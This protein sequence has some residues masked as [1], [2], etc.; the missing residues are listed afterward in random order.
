MFGENYSTMKTPQLSVIGTAF[1]VATLLATPA[2]SAVEDIQ[3]L[4]AKGRYAEAITMADTDLSADP[5]DPQTRFLKGIALAEMNRSDD[6]IGVFSRLTEDYPELPEPYNNL[7]VLYAQQRDFEKAR[8]ALE[9]AIRTHPSYATAHEN[10]GDVYARLASQA[11]NQALQID[12]ANTAAQSKL[13]L[14]REL[15]T[16]SAPSG[17]ATTVASARA[18]Q[19]TPANASPAPQMPAAAEM[20]ASDAPPPA[21]PAPAVAAESLPQEPA[22]VAAVE[23]TA[24]IAAAQA[25]AEQAVR[26]AV[27]GWAH[28]WSSKDVGAYLGFYTPDFRPANGKSHNTWKAERQQLVGEKPGEIEVA[29]ED[30]EITT[31]G[32]TATAYFRQ[33]YRSSGFN[34]STDKTLRLVATNGEWRI[35]EELIGRQ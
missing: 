22:A 14:I 18:A 4:I 15:M 32:D 26:D 30:V 12:S 7:A 21:G 9:M 35:R 6:A 11:Y 28:A 34:G 16:V 25:D 27:L 3:S 2:Q 5:K 23:S 31:D 1:F 29:L 8:S 20:R 17:A 13:A 10:L 19:S 24:P 33:H